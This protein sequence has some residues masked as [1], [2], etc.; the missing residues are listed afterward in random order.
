[1]LF[2]QGTFFPTGEHALRDLAR[3]VVTNHRK[4]QLSGGR[5]VSPEVLGEALFGKTDD[6]VCCEGIGS[7]E[8]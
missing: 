7:V 1:M 5:P 3:L 8:R 2:Q 4:L 6:A